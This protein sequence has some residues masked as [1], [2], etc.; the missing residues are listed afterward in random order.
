MKKFGGLT[1]FIPK[2]DAWQC[3]YLS[4]MNS[5]SRVLL[6]LGRGHVE[7]ESKKGEEV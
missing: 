5:C 3:I 6:C 1:V 4:V 2:V 7:K